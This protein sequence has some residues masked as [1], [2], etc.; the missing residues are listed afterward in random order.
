MRRLLITFIALSAALAGSVAHAQAPVATPPGK[1]TL[2]AKLQDCHTGATPDQRYAVFVGQMPAIAGAKRMAMRFELFE[3]TA[4]PGFKLV[5]VPKWGVWQKSLANQTGFVFQ[6]R[7]DTLV[8]PATYRAV[9]SF[10]WYGAHNKVI[11]TAQKISPLCKQPDPRPDLLVGKVRA[12]RGPVKG[13]VDYAVTVRND[14]LSDAGPFGLLLTVNGT[15]APQATVSGLATQVKTDVVVT[16]PACT[17]GS[18][19]TVALD[20]ANQVAESNETNNTFTRACP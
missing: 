10:R 5:G 12:T 18:T 15:P 13:T 11:R 19:I 7:V 1:L 8:G 20:P 9:V 6:K 16:A 17:P 14:G 2:G 3:R 4:G